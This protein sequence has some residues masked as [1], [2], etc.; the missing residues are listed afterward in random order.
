MPINFDD[1]PQTGPVAEPEKLIPTDLSNVRM[2]YDEDGNV[3]LRQSVPFLFD[4]TSKEPEQERV[5]TKEEEPVTQ[6]PSKEYKELRRYATELGQKNSELQKRLDD[7]TYMLASS[8]LGR[9]AQTTTEVDL[10]SLSPAEREKYYDELLDRKLVQH[11]KPIL[12]QMSTLAEQTS[13]DREL[14]A[15]RKHGDFDKYTEA[16]QELYR[17]SPSANIDYETAYFIV[18]GREAVARGKMAPPNKESLQDVPTKKTRQE[19]LEKERR[20]STV[21]GITPVETKD[22]MPSLSDAFAAAA[23]EYAQIKREQGR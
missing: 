21:R 6:E 19:L 11:V 2:D 18:K 10:E 20:L 8:G 13:L 9:Q 1:E 17:E 16:I 12:D 3:V 7:L 15:A 4:E 14:A 22:D 23:R 5:E